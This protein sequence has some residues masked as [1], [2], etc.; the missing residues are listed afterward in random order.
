[1]RS[2][3]INIGL[4]LLFVVSILFTFYTANQILNYLNISYWQLEKQITEINQVNKETSLIVN[5]LVK[6]QKVIANQILDTLYSEAEEKQIINNILNSSVVVM[7][8]QGMGSGTV[9]KKTND[10][11]YILT[12]EHVVD[13][14]IKLKKKTGL[15]LGARVGYLKETNNMPIGNTTYGAE[16]IK[17]NKR[18]DLALLKVY[19]NDDMLYE[20]P[21]AD[22]F[23]VKGDSIYVVGNPLG[24]VRTI[25][26]GIV[27]NLVDNGIIVDATLTFGNSGGG[28]FNKLGELIGVP[29]SVMAYAEIEGVAI[30]ESSLGY[31]IGLQTI[32]KFVQEIFDG[33]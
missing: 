27:S 15:D 19:F 31:S 33:K 32:K 21:I 9:I 3:L 20:A 12:C 23:P 22:E 6:G 2:K 16:I 4:V 1:M 24:V 25:S 28:L 29:A 13:D 14:V 18:I 26:K 5:A 11:M 7:G 30:P 17:Y 8:L 10:S